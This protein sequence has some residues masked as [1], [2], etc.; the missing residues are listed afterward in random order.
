MKRLLA[1]GIFLMFGI[2]FAQP[3][4][5]LS[6]GLGGYLTS[7]FGGGVE[8]SEI[9]QS[10][11]AY[12]T[13][14]F[15][16]SGE[17]GFIFLD[18]TFA[19]LS[20]GFF[21]GSHYET[22]DFLGD[23]KE[24]DLSYMGL[25]ISLLGKYPITIKKKFLLYPLLGANYRIMLSVKNGY[26][27]QYKNNSGDSAPEDFSAL[28]F[29]LGGGIDYPFTEHIFLRTQ[30]L[31]GIR[32]SNKFEDDTVHF[33]EKTEGASAKARIGHGLDIKLA[34]GYQF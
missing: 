32:L 24:N 19:E 29:R 11:S 12:Y 7:D 17:G 18:A 15:P 2:T 13:Y 26:E 10:V 34:I 20:L 33:Y 14:G 21:V 25:D 31:Y 9:S 27:S 16:Y 30:A 8:V 5:K 3:D 22:I 1:S 28:W 4:F 23:D 6:M